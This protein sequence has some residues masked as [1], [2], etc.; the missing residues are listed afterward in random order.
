MSYTQYGPGDRQTWSA[1][2]RKAEELR[3][4]D[5]ALA[6]QAE[7]IAD[8]AIKTDSLAVLIADHEEDALLDLL[9]DAHRYGGDTAAAY[10]DLITGLR[11]SVENAAYR[12]LVSECEEAARDN[13]DDYYG[14]AA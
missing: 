14:E 5:E 9:L 3:E 7:A 4:R 8:S 11:Q 6:E 12:R 1:H 13:G 10:R 2:V